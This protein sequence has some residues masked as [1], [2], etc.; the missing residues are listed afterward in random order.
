MLPKWHALLGIPFVL[1]L[2]LFF[3]FSLLALTI[4][5]LVNFFIDVDHYIWYVG[6]K[7]DLSLKNAFKY[8]VKYGYSQKIMYLFHTIEF[9]IILTVLTYYFNALVPL[10]IGVIFHELIDLVYLLYLKKMN[11]KEFSFFVALKKKSIFEG[12]KFLI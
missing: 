4:I 1:I 10:F 8:L 5:F 7:K 2:F 6:A 11:L 12:V 9:L 3:D